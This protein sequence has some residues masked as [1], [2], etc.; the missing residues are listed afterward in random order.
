MATKPVATKPAETKPVAT[1]PAETKPAETKPNT[2]PVS[3]GGKYRDISN[4]RNEWSYGY[5]TSWVS[6]YQGYWNFQAG[7]IYLTMDLGYEA[8]YTDTILDTLK[9]NG[10]KATF[11]VTTEYITSNEARVKRMLAEG[12]KVGNHSTKHINMVTLTETDVEDLIDNTKKWEKAYKA[13]TGKTSHL[14]RAPE[15]VFSKR[16]MAVLKDLGY[17][18]IFWGA[19]Y[20]DYD[21]SNQPSIETAR[22]KLYKY[23]DSGDV[24]L[25]HPFKTN[26]EFLPIFIE[27]MRAKGY[28]FALVP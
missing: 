27:E 6:D 24:I 26:A 16:G 10:V 22:E 20:A 3:E 8:G 12:H 13:A 19:A 9:A 23:I 7:N 11:F 25:L 17:D 2:K 4:K 28:N 15:G 21:E 1:K 18:N 5:P 14:Y